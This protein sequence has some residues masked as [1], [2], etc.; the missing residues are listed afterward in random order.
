MY[1]IAGFRFFGG[2]G[3]TSYLTTY[4]IQNGYGLDLNR[5]R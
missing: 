3:L 1:G 2:F 5:L 4:G